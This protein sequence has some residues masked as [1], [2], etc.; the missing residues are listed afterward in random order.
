MLAGDAKSE[1]QA[2]T[3]LTG[4]TP[5]WRVPLR[6]RLGHSGTEAT[7]GASAPEH[8]PEKWYRFSEK[9]MLHQ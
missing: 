1:Y 7:Q 2:K 5:E 3:S 9:F 4:E 8:D 6:Q